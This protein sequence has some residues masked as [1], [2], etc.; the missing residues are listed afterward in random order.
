MGKTGTHEL[1]RSA[2]WTSWGFV[3]LLS[4]MA[5]RK[6]T[7]TPISYQ[8]LSMYIMGWVTEQGQMALYKDYFMSMIGHI[9]KMTLSHDTDSFVANMISRELYVLTS[10]I[11]SEIFVWTIHSSCNESDIQ[12][13]LINHAHSGIQSIRI[14]NI[15]T[16]CPDIKTNQLLS[17]EQ[18]FGVTSNQPGKHHKF[19]YQC[20][21]PTSFTRSHFVYIIVAFIRIYESILHSRRYIHLRWRTTDLSWHIISQ[22]NAIYGLY[23]WNRKNDTLFFLTW[24][25][26]FFVVSDTSY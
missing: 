14:L 8:L 15:T 13:F 26:D 3:K 22:R 11:Y 12:H 1:L 9:T 20:P 7:F 16:Q 6:L 4:V 19:I 10:P 23:N 24:P 17:I 5:F 21:F 18:W 25:M 2:S